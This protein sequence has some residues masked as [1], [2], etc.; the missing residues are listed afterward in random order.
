MG[1]ADPI[2]KTIL[3]VEDDHDT[4][5]SLR[6]ILEGEGYYVFSAANGN[7]AINLL[8]VIKPPCLILLDILMPI[9]NGQEFLEEIEKDSLLHA[10]PVIV[11]SAFPQLAKKLIANAFLEKPID[12]KT[13]L[14][15]VA[16]S[17]PP[18]LNQPSLEQT[19]PVS[20]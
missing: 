16:E 6:Q 11:V 17:M 2:L 19:T 18:P 14:R 1:Q 12:L 15:L 5:V 8:R 3:I 20:H 13:L 10:V 9:M 7:Q 4:R